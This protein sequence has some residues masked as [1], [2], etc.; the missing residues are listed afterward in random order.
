MASGRRRR[1]GCA[2]PPKILTDFG[3]P[4]PRFA[5]AAR[6]L[7][8]TPPLAQL[9]PSSI[10]QTEVHMTDHD[11]RIRTWLADLPAIITQFDATPAPA[12]IAIAKRRRLKPVW[13]E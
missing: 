11:Q 6:T 7:T 5:A 2:V 8:P 4:T 13:Q 9:D 1:Q 12:T 10:E 3:S